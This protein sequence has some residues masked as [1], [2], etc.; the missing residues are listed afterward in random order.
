M[1]RC[2]HGHRFVHENPEQMPQRCWLRLRPFHCLLICRLTASN[3]RKY[4]S[5]AVSHRNKHEQG[6]VRPQIPVADLSSPFYL[7]RHFKILSQRRRKRLHLFI[8]KIDASF[9][10]SAT[11][12]STSTCLSCWPSCRRS[13]P[14]SCATSC[15]SAPPTSAAPSR[16]RT[17]ASCATSWCW[18]SGSSW[19][20]QRRR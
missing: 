3:C 20:S 15:R 19:S 13:P 4:S 2:V 1:G 9:F 16:T 14:R 17:S 7:L 6:F 12:Q 8:R 18:S 10:C 11:P 5:I